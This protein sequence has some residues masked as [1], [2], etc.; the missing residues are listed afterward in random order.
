MRLRRTVEPL[1]SSHCPSQTTS[2]LERAARLGYSTA[3]APRLGEV[4]ASVALRAEVE[5]EGRFRL[6]LQLRRRRLVTLWLLGRHRLSELKGAD[7]PARVVK[8]DAH[9]HLVRRTELAVLVVRPLEAR[10]HSLERVVCVVD[11]TCA[12]GL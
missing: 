6:R 8:E 3:H 2:S 11:C 7:F 4:E 5:V 12:L 9:E 1:S 10:S